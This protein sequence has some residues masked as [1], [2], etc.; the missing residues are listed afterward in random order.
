MSQWVFAEMSGASVR[1]DPQE[2][3]LF[4]TEDAGENEYAGTDALVREVIQNSMDAA[5]GGQPVRVRFG[6]HPADDLPSTD[7]L[8]AY[9]SRLRPALAHRNIDYLPSGAPNLQLGYLVCEDFGTRGLGGDVTLGKDPP[10]RHPTREDFF[11][12]WRNIGRS[13]KTG[14]DL[15]R[16]GLGKTVYRAASRVGCM[17]GLTVRACDNLQ[18]LMGQAVLR[19]HEHQGTE[20]APE[21]FWCRGCDATGL[22]VPIQDEHPIRCFKQEWSITRTTESGLSVVVPYVTDGLQAESILRLVAINF[23][24]PVLRGELIVE[25]A[26][27]GLPGHQSI[28]RIDSES[29]DRVCRSLSWDGKVSQKQSCPPPIELAKK[30]LATAA[31]ASTTRLLGQTSMPVI[32]EEAFDEAVTQ[33]LRQRYADGQLI[34]VRVR[35]ALPRQKGPDDEGEA[36]VFLR[37]RGGVERHESYFIR[38]GMTITRLN[39][40]RSLRGVEAWVSVEPGPLASLLGDTEGP[41]HI[42]WD[43]SNDERANQTWKKWKGRVRFFSRIVDSLAEFLSPPSDEADF[44]LLSDFFSVDKTLAPKPRQRQSDVGSSNR[45]F[46]RPDPT[47]RWYRSSAK[48]GGFR[49]TASRDL[50]VP[51]DAWLRI[52]VAYDMAGGDPLRHWAKFD[53]DFSKKEKGQIKFKGSGVVASLKNGNVVDLKITEPEFDLSVFGFDVHRDLFVRI[54]EIDPDSEVSK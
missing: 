10:K 24:V 23:F 51:K 35:A 42:S 48:E 15:G 36:L 25:V 32:D 13:G 27:P 30:S 49:V 33:D 18:Y 54:E 39:S 26:G 20:Y 12:F 47:P 43:T 19:L 9:F 1:R 52:A 11:W 14:D 6:L 50:P 31:A 40:K 22:P 16:W 45:T 41:S 2:T 46:V 5:I 8:A 4:K 21:G 44:E 34:G 38:E 17:L 53:F 3:E 7:R 28:V 37:R 29:I